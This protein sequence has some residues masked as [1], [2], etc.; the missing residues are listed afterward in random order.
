MKG[1]DEG[2]IRKLLKTPPQ[3]LEDMIYSVLKRI[4][5]DPELDVETTARILTWVS[6]SRRPLKFG[7]LDVITRLASGTTNWMLW[8]NMTGKFASIFRLRYPKGYDPDA[9]AGSL[10]S[11]RD[12]S[13]M[14]EAQMN[15]VN[16]GGTTYASGDDESDNSSL[17]WEPEDVGQSDP[18]ETEETLD[19]SANTQAEADKYYDWYK[20]NTIVEFTHVRFRD[21][22]KIEGNPQKRQREPL[23][24]LMDMYRADISIVLDS[25]EM[26]RTS[27]SDC[28]TDITNSSYS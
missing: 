17:A 2:Q 8:P 25:L 24:I 9:A 27:P 3:S 6:F 13:T 21:V 22:A 19:S 14:A 7:E 1:K 23:S 5:Q 11:N 12:E 26:M 16:L 18:G 10:I 28:K 15:G 20:K 4:S